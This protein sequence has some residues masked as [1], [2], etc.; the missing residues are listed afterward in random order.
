MRLLEESQ[1]LFAVGQ[2]VEEGHP[3]QCCFL[4]GQRFQMPRFGRH[5]NIF[6]ESYIQAVALGN[7][8]S[9]HNYQ[10]GFS[11]FSVVWQCG[12]IDLIQQSTGA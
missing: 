1:L 11:L 2:E 9:V 12:V 3:V 6:I 4:G 8:L 5:V 10:I 7:L